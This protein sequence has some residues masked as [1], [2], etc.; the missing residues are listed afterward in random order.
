MVGSCPH[1]R[2]GTKIRNAMTERIG[3]FEST[4]FSD[5]LRQLN[6]LTVISKRRKRVSSVMTEV[7]A[8]ARLHTRVQVYAVQF[9]FP[10]QDR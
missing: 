1:S 3:D 5:L 8:D 4:Y 6:R 7:S 2:N 9:Q 10:S